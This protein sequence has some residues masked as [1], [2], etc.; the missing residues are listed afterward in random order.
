MSNERVSVPDAA[1]LPD[2]AVII[3]T[4]NSAADLPQCLASLRSEHRARAIFVMDSGSIDDTVRIADQLRLDDP[5]ISVV[6]LHRNVGFGCAAN[7]GAA[8]SSE[9][10]LMFLNPDT[11]VAERCVGAL[12][13]CLLD[14]STVVVAGPVVTNSD[15]SIYPSAR[16]FPSLLTAIGHAFVGL[17]APRNRWSQR[18]LRPAEPEWISGTALMV[19]RSEFEA[20]GGFDE[21][22]FMYVEDVDLCWRITRASAATR[23]T[24]I[25]GTTR[26]TGTTGTTDATVPSVRRVAVVRDAHLTHRIAGSSGSRPY[27]LIVAHHQS[28]WRFARRSS[29]GWRRWSL[30]VVFVG[31]VARAAIVIARY[32]IRPTAQAKRHG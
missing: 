17:V 29:T 30:P 7:R 3:V 9:R 1:A 14:D 27:R 19:R 21:R 25:T 24:G 10:H 16:R 18:Y 22:Y 4:H 11:M 5:R 6:A 12:A 15:G 26:T 20:I 13:D 8:L 28:L 31:L 32:R 2:V 23:T